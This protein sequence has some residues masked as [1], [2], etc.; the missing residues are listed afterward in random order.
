MTSSQIVAEPLLQRFARRALL[1]RAVGIVAAGIATPAAVGLLAACSPPPG[2]TSP[3]AAAT[4]STAASAN[5]AVVNATPGGNAAAAVAKSPPIRIGFIPLTDCSSVAMASE[6]GLYAK[7]GVNVELSREASWANVRDKLLSGDLEAAH[8]LFGMP[9][10]VYT[11]VGG[12]AGRELPIAMLLNSNGQA[13]TLSTAVFRPAVGYGASEVKK[14]SEVVRNLKAQ[15]RELTFAMTFPGGTHDMWLRYWLAAAGVPQDS[16]KIITIPPPQMV[17]NMKVGNMDGYNV[18]EPW[19]GVAAKEGIGFT[20]VATQ[21]IWQNHPE[22]ALVLN[23][24]FF[25]QRSNDVKSVMRAIF[26]AA[27]WLDIP[28]N[29]QKAAPIVGGQAYVNAPA[30]VIDARLA[31]RYDLGGGLGEHIYTDD[32]MQF[33]NN[34]KVNFPRNG[35]AVWFLAQYVRFGLLETPPDYATIPSRLIKQD[36]YREV[37]KEMAVDIPDDDMAPI[38]PQLDGITFDPRDP[39][40]SLAKYPKVAAL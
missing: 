31:G 4:V 29:R 9:F 6:L 28:E 15:G 26:E 20:Q 10:S 5:T 11:G 18:G 23:Q 1:R 36:L 17:A 32:S 3:P 25:E 35:Y 34:G 30:D 27:A 7:H 21:D 8:C 16:V 2:Q 38:T 19:G 40:V 37:A 39:S 24:T 22:K 33:S 14:V 12:P 13:T